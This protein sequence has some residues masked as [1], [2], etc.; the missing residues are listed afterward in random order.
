ML[1]NTKSK[2]K[3]IRA[4]VLNE[5]WDNHGKDFDK[6]WDQIDKSHKNTIMKS[7]SDWQD[8]YQS[9]ANYDKWAQKDLQK[10]NKALILSKKLLAGAVSQA[11]AKAKTPVNTEPVKKI[12]VK[13]PVYIYGKVDKPKPKPVPIIPPKV[14]SNREWIIGL[15][16]GLVAAYNM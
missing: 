14:K 15:V 2:S 6:Y 1:P 16:L 5:A 7:L 11:N 4:S 8:Y 12:E 13:E 10:W 3:P 9:D